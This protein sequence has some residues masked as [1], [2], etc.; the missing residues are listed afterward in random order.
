MRSVRWCYSACAESD[1]TEGNAARFALRHVFRALN[2][3]TASL[4]ALH[5]AIVTAAAVPL[6]TPLADLFPETRRPAFYQM[7]FFVLVIFV[8][9]RTQRKGG[10]S[11]DRE[12]APILPKAN[13]FFGDAM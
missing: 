2:H 12:R 9:L 8:S 11:Q 4:R 3:D 6:W 13:D 1:F 5:D 10:A 7:A